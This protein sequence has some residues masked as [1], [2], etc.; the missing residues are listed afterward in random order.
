MWFIEDETP[1]YK[2]Q[3]KINRVL[4][5]KQTPYQYLEVIEMEEFG[6]ALLLDGAI[7]I[8]EKDEFIYNEMISHV[9]M[10]THPNPGKVLIIGGG[11]GGAAREV[12]KYKEVEEVQLI[13]IDEEVINAI[14]EFFPGLAGVFD[15]PRFKLI[16]D[17]GIEFVKSKQDEYDVII[18]DSSDPVGPAVNLFE[19]PFY[20]DCF[21][22]LK[23]D[24][25]L[26][27]QSESPFFNRDIIKKITGILNGLFEYV[28]TYLACIPTY[29]S[30]LWSFTMASKAYNYSGASLER[31]RGMNTHYFTPD[32]FQACFKLPR[33][34]HDFLKE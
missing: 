26:N 34:V 1:G 2:L 24:G 14:R 23:Q 13:E 8:T 5:Q 3:W 9:P 16:V 32:V 20:N 10:L 33:F 7:Q 21:R 27:I 6:R 25:I 19:Y 12:L 11:D 18:V 22:A 4:L 17:D 15:D 30:G 28:N 31:A 29:P